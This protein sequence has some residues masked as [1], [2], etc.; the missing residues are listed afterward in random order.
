MRI[1]HVERSC[2]LPS[3][4]RLILRITLRLEIYGPVLQRTELKYKEATQF[5][6]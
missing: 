6:M 3:F 1:D 5:K 2:T 4:T